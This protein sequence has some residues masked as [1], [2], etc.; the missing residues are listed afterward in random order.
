M[1][2][3][4]SPTPGNHDGAWSDEEYTSSNPDEESIGEPHSP[5]SH[6][7]VSSMS[8]IRVIIL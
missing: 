5:S 2:S 7:D 3:P 4:E 8:I 1:R 6:N